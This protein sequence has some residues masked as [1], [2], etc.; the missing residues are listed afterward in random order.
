M[1]E[2]ALTAGL[3]GFCEDRVRIVVVENHDVIGAAAG[4]VREMTGLVA[5]KSARNGHRFGKHTMGS[6]V[7][8]GKDGQRCHDVWWRNDG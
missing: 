6:D 5:E 1:G 7:G 3:N 4:G 2:L 8:I